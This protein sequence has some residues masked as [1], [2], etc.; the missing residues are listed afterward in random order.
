V[1]RRPPICVLILDDEAHVR[2]ILADYLQDLGGFDAHTAGTEAEALDVLA[3]AHVDVCLVDLRLQ[4]TE[5]LALIREASARHPSVRFLIHTGSHLADVR[6]RART[7][8]LGEDRI[9]LKPMSMD[10]I[11]A[12]IE[13]VASE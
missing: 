9:L 3:S 12:A 8:G 6:E 10:S 4:G 5:G 7:V 13:R 1:P 2:G 11:A